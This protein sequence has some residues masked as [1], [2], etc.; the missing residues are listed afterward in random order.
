MNLKNTLTAL[1][2]ALLLGLFSCEKLIETDW[3]N[4]QISTVQVFE[5]VQT[6]NAALAGLYGGLWNSSPLSGG[7]D[8]MGAV[9][10]TYTDDLKCYYPTSSNGILDIYLNQQLPTNLMVEKVWGTGYQYIYAANAI[11]E[12]AEKSLS[13]GSADKKRIKGEAL[14][15][16]SVLYYSLQRI[17]GD[18]PYTET[19]D[20]EI[21]RQLKKQP[22]TEVLTKLETDLSLSTQLLEDAYRSPERIY[23]NRKAAALVLAKV[24]AELGKWTEAE[25]LL[26][27][28]GQ[29]SLYTFEQDL[30]KVF[31]KS[32]LHIL[33]QLKPKNSGDA[34]KE[35]TLY[36]FTN[37]VPTAFAL[38]P[39]LVGAFAPG[40]LRRQEWMVPVTASA[41]TFYRAA[42]YKVRSANTTEYS[43]V[44][45][46]EEVYLLLAEA[47][48]RQGKVGEALPWLNA[49]RQRAGL[50]A[51]ALPLTQNEA[52][53]ELENEYRREFFAEGG[54][55]FLTL[56]RLG[57]LG[58]LTAVKPNWQVHHSLWPLPQKELLL[59]TNLNP[60]NPGY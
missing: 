11:M 2:A 54:Q 34:T 46:L 5:D 44:Y 37:A 42:K 36:Y 12:G 25:L 28:I 14:F 59:N 10:G 40:D 16:R 43:V 4:N 7:S 23:P 24:K 56:K 6:A 18:I 31:T 30:T 47:L 29:S 20:Y 3:P 50:P 52:L 9:L 58:N 55:R 15:V 53:T 60:Q 45:R 51:L 8:G 57:K 48:I 27:D 39:Q 32:R 19:T 17:Y 33:W 49:T 1:T 41:Q 21:N 35:A 13:L 38:T 22:G 26:K